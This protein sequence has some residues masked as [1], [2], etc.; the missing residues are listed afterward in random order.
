MPSP[1]AAG[2]RRSKR[3]KLILKAGAMRIVG[4]MSS[5]PLEMAIRGLLHFDGDPGEDFSIPEGEEALIPHDSLSWRI[6]KNPLA[7]FVGGTAAVLLELAEPRVR[8]GVWEHSRFR[9]Q[10]LIRMRRTGFAALTTVYGARSVSEKMIARIVRLHEAIDGWTP[11]GQR[12]CANNP[13]L[14]TWV[15]ATATFSFF[16]AYNRYVCVQP[17]GNADSFCQEGLS[18]AALYGAIYAPT[19]AHE[20]RTLFASMQGSLEASP[21]VFEFLE[22]MRTTPILPPIFRPLQRILVRAAI[23]ILPRWIQRSLELG[24]TWKIRP[25]EVALV[26]Q[27]GRRS[28]GILIRSSPAVQACARLGLPEDYLYQ[29]TDIEPVL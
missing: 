29:Q 3:G 28:D 9:S 17:R 13:D 2:W 7:L 25:W 4:P 5:R 16:Q 6:F 20:M 11:S 24:E 12:Y 8:T 22:I 1:A 26:K 23:D 14:L 21:I 10:P 19:S 18:A 27:I 15:H